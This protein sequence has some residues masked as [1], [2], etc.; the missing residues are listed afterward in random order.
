MGGGGLLVGGGDWGTY[1]WVVRT[2][3]WVV[4]TYWWVV[5]SYWW[6]VAVEKGAGY[7]LRTRSKVEVCGFRI[8]CIRCIL[9]ETV[10]EN[11]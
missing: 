8:L 1:W 7:G 3:W 6:V 10:V 5:G 11:L 4:G 9:V 2:Y